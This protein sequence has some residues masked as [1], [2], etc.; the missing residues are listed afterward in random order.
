[1]LIEMLPDYS[2]YVADVKP[3][4]AVIGIDLVREDLKGLLLLCHV[5]SCHLPRYN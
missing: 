5:Q 2:M 3:V 1:M 4:S